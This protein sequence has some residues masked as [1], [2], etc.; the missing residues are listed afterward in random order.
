MIAKTSIEAIQK[1]EELSRQISPQNMQNQPTFKLSKTSFQK[2]IELKNVKK[3]VGLNSK[4]A[5]STPK[6]FSVNQTQFSG[7]DIQLL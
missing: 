2:Y 7:F 3:R 6:N 4:T 5:T 1:E